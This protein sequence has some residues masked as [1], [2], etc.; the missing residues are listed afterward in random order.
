MRARRAG[1]QGLRNGLIALALAFVVLALAT[2]AEGFFRPR[3][4]PPDRSE[5][6]IRGIDVSHHQGRIDWPRVAADDVVFAIIKA[7]E[8]GD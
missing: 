1:S 4:F 5:F 2:W 8:G 3:A 6:P 7:T